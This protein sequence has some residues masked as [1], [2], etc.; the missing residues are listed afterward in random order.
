MK[1]S[2]IIPAY[3]EEKSIKEIINRVKSIKLKIQKEII[4]VDDCSTDSTPN[5]LKDIKDINAITHSINLGKGAAIKSALKHATG[6]LILI[7]DADL[8]YNPKDYPVLLEPLIKDECDAVYGNRFPLYSGNK[9][10]INY[11]GNRFLSF[12][13][14]LLYG[15]SLADMETGYKVFKKE[16]I[17]NIS[18]KARGFD[19]EPEITAKLLKK[20]YQIKEVPINY[21]PRSKKDGKKITLLDGVKAAFYLLK[22]RF[23]D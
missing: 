12:L 14:M 21:N 3:N 11:F 19:F 17:K 10:S 20:N 13:T 23:M 8:E 18:L 7:Q 16:V 1:I 22:Y 4:V 15:K 5:F 6:D 9:L 2:I